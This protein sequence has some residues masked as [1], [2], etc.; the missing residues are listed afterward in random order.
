MP[1]VFELAPSGRSKCR[2]CGRSIDR[3]E[4]RFGERL[5]NPFANGDE[6]T[7][8]FHP[9]CAAFKRPEPLLQ[10][11]GES[12]EQVPDRERL[13][14]TARSGLEHPRLLRIDGA[15]RAA[16][17]QAKCRHCHEPI[18]RGGWRIKLAFWE[19]GRFSAGGY[20]HLDCRKA[21]FETD[22]GLDRL[23]YFSADLGDADREELTRAC[24][25]DTTPPT[26]PPG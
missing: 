7:V 2:G 9:L 11:L 25:G 1:H 17:G 21:Y 19:E 3:S 18:A 5:P 6:M 26:T 14:R 8:W 13:E 10:A 22:A 24:G 16:S 15:E 4:L 23:L 20:L 12:P